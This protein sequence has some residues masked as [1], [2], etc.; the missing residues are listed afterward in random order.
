MIAPVLVVA[1]R[2]R[3]LGSLMTIAMIYAAL[4]YATRQNVRFLYVVVPILSSAAIWAVIELHRFPRLPG[5][6]ALTLCGT[7]IAIAAATPLIRARDK[8]PVALGWETR[9]AYLLRNEPT[10]AA[11]A[12]ANVMMSET[13]QILTQDYRGFYFRCPVVREV[14][15][16]RATG[17]N[18]RLNSPDDLPQLLRQEGFTFLL[19]AEN[20]SRQGIRYN[21]TLS[22]LIDT[23]GPSSQS[24]FDC[25]VD[26]RFTDRDGALRRYRLLRLR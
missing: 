25:L 13:D 9:E 4:W 16:R 14:S 20:A 8:V 18:Q 12:V 17:Y 23:C 24:E 5:R 19:L 10:Y 21:D 1:R 26:Y 11:A 6:I 3:G 22:R 2:L 7:A 15:F